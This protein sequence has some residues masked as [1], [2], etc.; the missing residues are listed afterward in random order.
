MTTHVKGERSAVRQV[1]GTA[2][3][4][5]GV[6]GVAGLA[7]IVTSRLIIEHYGVD[8]FAQYGL[9]TGLT[10]LMPFADLGIAAVLVNAVASA[11]QP[12]T[13]REVRRTITSAFRI[14]LVSATVI[15]TVAVTIGALGWWPALLGDG[16]MGNDGARAATVCLV[17]FALALPLG[18]G[19]R[20]LVALG[21][22]AQQTALGGI[23]SPL[24]L[25][26][27]AASVALAWAFG[28]YVAVLSY[29]ANATVAL[30]S[31][32]LAARLLSP[33]VVAAAR[34]VP[35]LRSVRGAK[36]VD[37]AWPML[38]QMIA[39]PIAMQ[40][41]RLLLSHLAGT[42]ELAQYNLG[43]QTFGLINQ[44]VAAAGV[45]LWPL[46]ARA[47]A[48]GRIESPARATAVFTGLAATLGLLLWLALPL[49]TQVITKGK[50]E[51]TATFAASFVLFVVV[52][53]A[54]YPLGMYMTDAAGLRFQVVPVVA[55]VPINL[56][57]SWLLIEPLGAAGPVL[58]SAVS[59]LVCQ[60]VPNAWYVRRDL[61]RRRRAL[62]ATD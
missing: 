30:L 3:V 27:V 53:A 33:Q 8:A 15:A 23:A 11:A 1:G 56:G 36:V 42:S 37:V 31:L 60:V 51:L 7:G 29:V 58:G 28:P 59:V 50:I 18:V 26:G 48:A 32:V 40:T 9:L 12:R 4:K 6:M 55:M 14:L 49:V 13:D 41:D 52:Q 62:A 43:A 34:D 20:V 5:V 24:V 44:V 16:L 10:G 38:V 39:L 19:Q 46:Y 47:R 57:L 45:A 25:C 22:T 54:K 17:V 21:R 61:A 2:A 35:R